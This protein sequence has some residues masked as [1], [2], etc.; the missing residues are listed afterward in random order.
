[1]DMLPLVLSL[2]I[3]DLHVADPESI[4]DLL[5]C[6]GRKKDGH[7]ISVREFC[8]AV[9]LS[10][11]SYMPPLRVSVGVVVSLGSQKEVD[12]VDAR[13]RIAPMQDVE[14]VWNRSV[15]FYPCQAVDQVGLSLNAYPDIPS[16]IRKSPMKG[17]AGQ[18]FGDGFEIEPLANRQMRYVPISHGALL[19]AA[20]VRAG[21]ALQA[22]PG[23]LY[24]MATAD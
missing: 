21:A 13:S 2:D 22:L 8:R 1:M 18:G 12:R 9:T 5:V 15:F 3:A 6:P 19:T 4:A 16:R 7:G 14:S 23:P 24:S 11:Q 20:V 10:A 17:A